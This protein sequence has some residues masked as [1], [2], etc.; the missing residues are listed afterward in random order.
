MEYLSQNVRFIYWAGGGITE[1]AGRTLSGQIKLFQSYGSAESGM[2]TLLRPNEPW[3]N[4]EWMYIRIHPRYGIEFRHYTDNLYEAVMI[5]G[6]DHDN[7]PTI[8]K[9][10]PYL[11]EWPT[12]D[13]FTPHPEETGVWRYCSRTDD[14]LV[15]TNGH[16]FNPNGY[17]QHL[18]G[19]SEIRAA[20][21]AGTHRGQSSLLIE[22]E[23]QSVLSKADT[24]TVIDRIWPTI[25]V[26]NEA[27]TAQAKIDKSHIIF[28]KPEKPLPRTDKGTIKRGQALQLYQK[29]LD[30]LYTATGRKT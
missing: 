3:D 1:S 12:H 22:L 17:E 6:S 16:K 14:V 28:T 13:L 24:E 29:E 7:E 23:S 4:E 2:P 20:L 5:R 27:C 9:L 21:M 18:L 8:F 10:Q 25:S 26:A 15:F 30:S 11:N 19:H